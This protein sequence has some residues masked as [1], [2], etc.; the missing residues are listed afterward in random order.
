MTSATKISA[1]GWR[2]ARSGPISTVLRFESSY[3]LPT[4]P[5]DVIVTMR[6][7]PLHRVDAAIINGT[8]LGRKRVN[9][10][11]FPRVGG[12]EGVG[13]VVDPGANTT[14]KK[15]D[16][17]W[18]APINGSWASTVSVPS[19]SVHRIDPSNVA[20]AVYASNFLVAQQLLGGYAQLKEGQVIIQ[21]GGSSA[22]ALAVSALGKQY[23]VRVLTAA[24][25]SDRF[26]DAVARHKTYGSDVFTY[27]G[28]GARAMAAACGPDGAA[29]YLN[30]VGGPYFDTFM[31]MV[32][33]GGNV[34]TYGAQNGPGLL[35]SGSNLIFRASTMH[36]LFLP[37]FMDSLSYS[38]RQK[39]LETVL[40]D[41]HKAKFT[42]PQVVAPS[43]QG[44]PDVWDEV[45]LRGGRKGMVTLPT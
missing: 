29:L 9:V 5:G 13:V 7:A 35:L 4:N 1:A 37:T 2:Y 18:I 43:L 45:F 40:R 33:V 11:R 26:K 31:K 39:R 44:L 21:N 42:Y 38:E 28:K 36:G 15:G 6:A 41:L 12:C 34:V 30:C 32:G 27:D 17:V 19:Q 8:A 25:P 3:I 20:L 24:T 14:V 23:G 10:A 22:T 16:T